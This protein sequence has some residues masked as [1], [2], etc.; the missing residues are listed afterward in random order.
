MSRNTQ[1]WIAASFTYDLPL[2]TLS[3]AEVDDGALMSY[4][5]DLIPTGQQAA[6]LANAILNGTAPRDLPVE[7]TEYFLSVN[8]ATAQAIGLDVP[9]PLLRQAAVI[10]RGE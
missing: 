6:R 4:G 8:L 1:K 10:V 2:S 9:E 3:V 5:E 7:T